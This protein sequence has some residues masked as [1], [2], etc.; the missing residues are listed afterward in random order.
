M[1]DS[2][3]LGAYGPLKVQVVRRALVAVLRLIDLKG[4]IIRS[5]SL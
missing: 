4:T 5:E 2:R 3:H 1:Q